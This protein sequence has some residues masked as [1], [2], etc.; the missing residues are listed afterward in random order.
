MKDTLDLRFV[1]TKTDLSEITNE[2]YERFES[3]FIEL[4]ENY[5][6]MAG[7]GILHHSSV[8]NRTNKIHSEF[9]VGNIVRDKK[10]KCIGFIEKVSMD[11]SNRFIVSEIGDVYADEIEGIPA[12]E[13]SFKILGF[14]NTVSPGG[15]VFKT[16]YEKTNL[17][18]KPSC[19]YEPYLSNHRGWHISLK[20]RKVYKIETIHGLQNAW[21][22]ITGY[23]L[24]Y[25]CS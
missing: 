2:E 12:D 5:N 17:Q 8:Q 13:Q 3:D 15:K 11:N 19:K 20:R 16:S 23:K 25:T 24:H 18:L 4:V 22:D 10:S 1:V 9:R 7:G 14:K 21:E 6:M